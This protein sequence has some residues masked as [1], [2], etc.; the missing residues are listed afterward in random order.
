MI[1]RGCRRPIYQARLGGPSSVCLGGELLQSLLAGNLCL[2]VRDGRRVMSLLAE[3]LVPH[4]GNLDIAVVSLARVADDAPPTGTGFGAP[5]VSKL[6]V[7]VAVEVK[8]CVFCC[9]S[10][11]C[12]VILTADLPTRNCFLHGS[13][14]AFHLYHA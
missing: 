14:S 2:L 4:G 1:K 5:E 6:P 10:L 3:P 7:C 9:V 8:A 13:L 11:V 12:E